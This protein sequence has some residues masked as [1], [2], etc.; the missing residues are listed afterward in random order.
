MNSIKNLHS[1]EHFFCHATVVTQI[2]FGRTL[3]L[4]SPENAKS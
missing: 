1:L 2:N 4:F 3:K